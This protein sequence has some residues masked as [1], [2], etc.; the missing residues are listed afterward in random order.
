M[1]WLDKNATLPLV[2]KFAFAIVAFVSLFALA[3]TA[4]AGSHRTFSLPPQAKQIAPGVFDLGTSTDKGRPVRGLA[5]IHPR[6]DV[7]GDH[8]PNHKPG[9]K[10]GNGGGETSCFA[11]IA[12]DTK[13][14]VVEDYFV[15]PTNNDGYTNVDADIAA[16]MQAWE[17]AAGTDIFGA[18]LGSGGV[19][20]VDTSSTDGKNEIMF[21]NISEPGAI[22]VTVVWYTIGPPWARQIVEHDQMYDDPDFTWGNAGPASETSLGDTSVMDFL[23][24]ATHEIGHS[25]GMSHPNDSCTEETMY[26]FAENGETKKRTLHT[27]DIAGILKLYR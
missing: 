26:A 22:A 4:R 25:A 21:G 5:I 20:G 23:N 10:G 12:K 17:D 15:D 24:V 9:G 7:S 14:K 3:L 1:L 2:R 8:K 16:A 6:P 13:W 27:G 11:Y 18:N 19:D